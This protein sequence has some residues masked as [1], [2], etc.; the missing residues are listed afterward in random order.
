MRWS[1]PGYGTGGESWTQLYKADSASHAQWTLLG[2]LK[3]KALE[4]LIGDLNGTR[5]RLT[6][7]GSLHSLH[8]G[9]IV[10]T[11]PF[12]Q[13]TYRDLVGSGNL[14][15]LSSEH[16]ATVVRYHTQRA[17]FERA[18]ALYSNEGKPPFTAVIPAGTRQHLVGCVLGSLRDLEVCHESVASDAVRTMP[19]P[20][21]QTLREWRDRVGT[22]DQL[23]L[24]LGEAFVFQRYF[25]KLG[26]VLDESS[27]VLRQ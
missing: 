5:P 19:P 3:I 2:E 25:A 26:A 20:E 7:A 23:Q 22:R 10:P 9:S 15:L 1:A 4:E 12:A 16:R 11:P 13:A 18:M 27:R 8:L 17:S 24:E 21:L 14:R 6:E